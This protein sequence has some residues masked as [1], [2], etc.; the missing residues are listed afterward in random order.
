MELLEAQP[1]AP[2]SRSNRFSGTYR[3]RPA[4]TVHLGR[5]ARVRVAF[6]AED[7][8]SVT[9]LLDPE[10][11]LLAPARFPS[12]ARNVL[13][14]T[15]VGVER[16][17]GGLASTLLVRAGSLT[18]RVA[19]TEEPLRQLRLVPGRRVW[20]YVKA[21]ALRRVGRPSGRPI[22]GSPRR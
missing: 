2:P 4:P 5:G 17:T 11:I 15:V 10:S 6:A 8:E 7:G 9:V 13:P 3:A 18:L 19:V 16:T 20:L 12:S 1:V 22:R 14:A 21:T